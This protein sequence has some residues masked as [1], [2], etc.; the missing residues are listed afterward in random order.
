MATKIQHI[1]NFLQIYIRSYASIQFVTIS[2]HS[3][4]GLWPFRFVAISVCGCFGLCR[5]GLWPFR[6]VAVS[7]FG[8]WGLWPFGL[9]PLR[10]WP[11]RFVAVM[12]RNLPT[13]VLCIDKI[14]QYD[15]YLGQLGQLK[16]RHNNLGPGLYCLVG[17][18]QYQGNHIKW[19]TNVSKLKQIC[20]SR[21]KCTIWTKSVVTCMQY[22]FCIESS[23]AI[24]I[25][26]S[27]D[28]HVNTV[29]IYMP[30]KK[31]GKFANS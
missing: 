2:I 5:L 21:Y 13:K 18:K 24:V 7:V 15:N 11:F 23:I 19:D 6:F 14:T 3:R 4:F 25:M 8:R 22:E 29:K 1:F 9:W 31:L 27:D 28:R 26:P 20:F 12:T 16:D 30:C 10:F 17:W